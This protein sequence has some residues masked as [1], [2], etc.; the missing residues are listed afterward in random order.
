VAVIVAHLRQSELPEIDERLPP[1]PFLIFAGSRPAPAFVKFYTTLHDD[2]NSE[3]N[4]TP[5]AQK[6]T[7]D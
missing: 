6:P 4:Q 7:D 3:Y 1:R 2:A 5:F